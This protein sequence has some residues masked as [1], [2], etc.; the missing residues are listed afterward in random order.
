MGKVG[1]V[2]AAAGVGSPHRGGGSLGGS[3]E[4]D[5]WTKKVP[6]DQ[7]L[8]G[9]LGYPRGRAPKLLEGRGRRGEAGKTGAWGPCGHGQ[10]RPHVPAWAR[11]EAGTGPQGEI[12]MTV[13]SVWGR[14]GT[15]RRGCPHPRIRE[16]GR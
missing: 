10:F 3:L 1:W 8:D 12:K 2:D 7:G 6:P 11:E 4:K 16:P 9:I 15:P 14:E 13:V 5:T